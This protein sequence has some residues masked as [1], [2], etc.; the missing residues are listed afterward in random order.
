M[1]I[2]VY[3]CVCLYIFMCAMCLTVLECMDIT[4]AR[5]IC[6]AV[7]RELCN[8]DNFEFIRTEGQ[9]RDAHK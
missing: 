1:C 9:V 4:N 3:V 6:E 7:T 5:S 2:S 8:K